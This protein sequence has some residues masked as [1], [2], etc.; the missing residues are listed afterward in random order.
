MSL[1][2]LAFGDSAKKNVDT[3]N[4]LINTTNVTGENLLINP[5]FKLNSWGETQ[6]CNDAS[7]CTHSVDAWSF[8]KTQ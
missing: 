2:N 8:H 5:N 6:Y 3:L 7:T 4:K 1:S